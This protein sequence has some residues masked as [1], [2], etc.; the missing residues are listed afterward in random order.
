MHLVPENSSA[1]RF[2]SDRLQYRTNRV[3]VTPFSLVNVAQGLMPARKEIHVDASNATFHIR[4]LN[5]S[6][7]EGWMSALRCAEH[8]FL[9]LDHAELPRLGSIFPQMNV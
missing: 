4:C 3:S 7:F 2:L 5:M 1:T 6:D 8:V 9:S